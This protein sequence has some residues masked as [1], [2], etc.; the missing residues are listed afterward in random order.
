MKGLFLVIL[1]LYGCATQKVITAADIEGTYLINTNLKTERY[2]DSDVYSST[3]KKTMTY[4]QTV[5]E[6]DLH[7][8]LERCDNFS[9]EWFE[10]RKGILD[11][12]TDSEHVKGCEPAV[13]AKVKQLGGN[14]VEL[15]SA[16]CGPKSCSLGV[17]Y[18]RCE[19]SLLANIVKKDAS[20]KRTFSK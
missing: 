11:F 12:K 10:C 6:R 15:Y 5:A 13:R 3:I 7:Q 18:Y 8:S 20:Y 2:S 9:D 17:N 19:N 14:L 1:G 4:D 16:L